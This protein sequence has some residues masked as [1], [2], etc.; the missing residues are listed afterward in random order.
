MERNGI[1]LITFSNN[2]DHQNTLYSMFQ[3]LYPEH[4]VYTIGINN[5]KSAIAPH[6]DNNFYFECP[7]RPGFAKGSFRFDIIMK[8]V[9]LIWEKQIRYIY[10][11]NMHMWNAFLMIACRKV[12]KIQAVHDVIPHDGNKAMAV[13]NY[14]TSKLADRVILR[15]YKYKEL[16][17][18]KYHIKQEHITCFE[19]WRSFR[20]EEPITYS[21]TF[22]CFGRIRRYKGFDLLDQ[23][24]QKTPDINYHIVGEPDEE[25]QEIVEKLKQ[26]P[27]VEIVDREVSDIEMEAC[28]QNAD[29][30]VLPY[31]SATQSGV[32]TDACRFSRP[33]IAFDVGAISEQVADG[34]TGFLVPAG[35]IERFAETVRE[36]NGFSREE[37]AR[38]A[39]NAYEFG[40]KKYAAEAV[41]DKFVG[42]VK[43]CHEKL[44]G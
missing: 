26:H 42:V 30:I 4:E 38:F 32:I 1:C 37:T 9:R 16:L 7:L 20:K 13:C 27:N 40:Y 35:N 31:F 19:L 43:N 22:L 39:H 2:A 17:S 24:V 28:F 41:A 29:W 6:T 25:S 18:Q 8:M 44:K 36:A 14:V 33:V 15:N 21:K 12:V 11:E 3:A 5:P 23:I 34:E 10:F